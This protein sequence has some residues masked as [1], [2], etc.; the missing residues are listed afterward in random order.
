MKSKHALAALLFCGSALSFSSVAFG[1][2]NM[3]P[4]MRAQM[5]ADDEHHA[6]WELMINEQH[7]MDDRH[8]QDLRA[9]EDRHYNERKVLRDKQMQERDAM[10]EKMN[11][12][13]GGMPRKAPPKK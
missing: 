5:K 4:D 9:M 2:D 6:Q 3:P 12:M 13:D 8:F 11:P 7:K 10:F 1:L